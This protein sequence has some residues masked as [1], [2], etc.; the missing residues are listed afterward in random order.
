[1]SKVMQVA[2]G[3]RRALGALAVGLVVALLAAG[4]GAPT[5]ALRS[6]A[7]TF[8][9]SSHIYATP[10]DGDLSRGCSGPLASLAPGVVRCLVLRVDNALARDIAVESLEVTLDPAYAETQSACADELV[11]PDF[12]GRL[13]VPARGAARSP[14]LPILLRNTPTDQND[15]Q[16]MV[17]HFRLTGIATSVGSPRAE[18]VSP[19]AEDDGS[20]GALPDTGSP[21]PAGLL[22]AAVGAGLAL[23]GLGLVL[24]RRGRRRRVPE[25]AP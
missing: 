16:D 23:L 8:E 7:A 11:L 3:T 17:F 9:I 13:V 15:C 1:M 21:L 4:S 25:A 5:V 19:D 14:G 22:A 10:R 2:T 18:R 12:S 6:G 24:V 20:P